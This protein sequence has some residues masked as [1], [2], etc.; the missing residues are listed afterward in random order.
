MY[1]DKHGSY[2][3]MV[4]VVMSKAT[5][6]PDLSALRSTCVAYN[7]YALVKVEAILES[8]PT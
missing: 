1:D 3:I 8:H 2:R 4:M 7:E 5:R 6:A